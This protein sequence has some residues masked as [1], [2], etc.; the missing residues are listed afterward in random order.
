MRKFFGALTALIYAVLACSTPI[1]P[2]PPN[3]DAMRTSVAETVI[4]NLTL[5]PQL[6]PTTPPQPTP[7]FTEIETF[8]PTLTATLEPTSTLSPTPT[9]TLIPTF[10]FLP[11]ES[12]QISVSINTNCRSGPGKAYPIV[13]SLMVGKFA[14]VYGSDP[15]YR[16]WYIR[17]PGRGAEYCWVWTEY[18]TLTGHYTT[19]PIFTP[20]PTPT[21]TNTPLPSATPTPY[22][23][24]SMEYVGKDSC[25]N[26]WLEVRVKNT[27]LLP[28][29]SISFNIEDTNTG[30]KKTSL[31]DEFINNDG[32]STVTAKDKILPGAEFIVSSPKLGYDPSGHSI[33][34]RLTLCSQNG[35]KGEC[36]KQKIE[37]VP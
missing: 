5:A 16:Y 6:T 10:D 28:L 11:T 29:R 15:T 32:C 14:D 34:L 12:S 2:A 7:T 35:Q 22:P 36:I 31:N 4:S 3:E 21:P 23:K 26:W 9:F 27:G 30:K 18:A 37:I 13:G 1:N 33:I 20:P 24:F 25:S 17:N 19:L 8:T